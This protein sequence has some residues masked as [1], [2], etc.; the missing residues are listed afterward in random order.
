MR[1]FNCW[2]CAEVAKST[3]DTKA[4][5]VPGSGVEDVAVGVGA[6]VVVCGTLTFLLVI[7]SACLIRSNC[8]GVRQM[9]H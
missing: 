5:G 4:A 3:G 2:Y 7:P 1:V 8:C 9:V 6:M